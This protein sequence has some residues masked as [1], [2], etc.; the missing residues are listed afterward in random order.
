MTHEIDS[1]RLK[2][3]AEPADPDLV[4]PAR[5]VL[6][7]VRSLPGEG[8]LVGQQENDDSVSAKQSY[9]EDLTGKKPAIRGFD[10]AEYIVDPIE[11]AVD[12]WHETGQLVTLSWHVRMPHT[13]SEFDN[14]LDPPAEA[15]DGHPEYGGEAD[16][17]AVLTRGTDEHEW[18]METLNWMADRLD[19][20]AEREVPV[21]WRPYHE[22]D[23]GWFW[24]SNA[25]PE[26]SCKLWE[27]M[28]DHFVNERGLHNL[29]WVW[30]GSHELPDDSWYPGDECVDITGVDTY[31]NQV[32]DLDWGEQYR[33]VRDIS[34]TKPVALAECDELPHP[35]DVRDEHPFV[36]ALPWHGSIRFNDEAHIRDVYE[37]PY[38]VTAGDLPAFPDGG[39]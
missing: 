8:W 10:V 34:A 21:L 24:W 14:V 4:A 26:K 37:H 30:S 35:D 19:P 32:P 11:A 17:E 18:L 3:E 2:L 22:A 20:L 9:I 31:R 12:A 38:T 15:A 16:V 39:G 6:A 1:R 25:G 7:Y 33:N 13:E 28:F 29:V 36:W 27:R 23:G 5:T